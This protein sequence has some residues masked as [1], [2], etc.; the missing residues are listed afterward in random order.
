MIIST[1]I[2]FKDEFCL[3]HHPDWQG[4]IWYRIISPTGSNGIILI[5]SHQVGY[6]NGTHPTTID[7]TDCFLY[8][9]CISLRQKYALGKKRA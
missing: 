2:F 4:P 9:T 8:S 1:H 7:G 6:V 5:L 3:N